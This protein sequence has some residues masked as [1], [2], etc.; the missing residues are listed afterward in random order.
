MTGIDRCQPLTNHLLHLIEVFMQVRQRQAERLAL[1]LTIVICAA[2]RQRQS[3]LS[4]API[5]RLLVISF[6]S[7]HLNMR[8]D[9]F[10]NI[11]MPLNN[12]FRS[13]SIAELCP[14]TRIQ[15]GV[16]V[17]KCQYALQFKLQRVRKDSCIV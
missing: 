4:A 6:A 12:I 10:S 16:N 11:E 7:R 3:H 5:V 17:G 14:P 9:D 2:R 15:T 8:L 13:C 1:R